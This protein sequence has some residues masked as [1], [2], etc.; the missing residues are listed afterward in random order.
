VDMWPLFFWDCGF[1]SN[2]NYGWPSF[3]NVVCCQ[4]EVSASGLSPVQRSPTECGVS[5]C[6]REASTVRSWPTTNFEPLKFA[7]K[8]KIS[9]PNLCSNYNNIAIIYNK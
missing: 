5:E 7:I 3:V 1:E 6:G 9:E 2:R 4:I 8:I